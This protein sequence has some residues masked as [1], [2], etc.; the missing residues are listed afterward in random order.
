MAAVRAMAIICESVL[1]QLLPAIKPSADKHVLDVLPELWPRALAFVRAASADPSSVV[2]G[3]LAMD[4]GSASAASGATT[5]PGAVATRTQRSRLDMARIRRKSSGCEVVQKLLAAAF[6]AMGKAIANHAAE[7]LPA[8]ELKTDGSLTE[9]GKLCAANINPALKARYDAL[10][11]TSTSVERLHAIGRSVDQSAGLQRHEGR[12]GTSL[13]KFNDQSSWLLTKSSAA[14]QKLFNVTRSEARVARKTS[15]KQQRIASGRAKR[16]E[17]DAK[18]QTKRAR[19]EAKKAEQARISTV[20]LASTYSE[21]M[22]MAIPELQ[23]Q[24]KAWKL[25][26]ETGFTVTQADREAYVLQLQALIFDAH[27]SAANDLADGDS[28][29]GSGR[30]VRKRRVDGAGGRR[31]NIRELNGFQWLAHEEF[32]I[33]RLL[34]KKVEKVYVGKVNP[35]PQPNQPSPTTHNPRTITR[36]RCRELVEEP[37]KSST[38][39]FCGRATPPMWQPGSHQVKFTTILSTI[40]RLASKQK[41]NWK[42]KKRAW[43]QMTRTEVAV[44]PN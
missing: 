32:E 28:G 44:W 25:K 6:D 15:L 33:D 17:R 31:N 13:A 39:R 4:L 10:P 26:G 19:R 24:L 7:W 9:E 1:W 3:S 37:R 38:T 20:K 41:L 36:V 16:A 5:T 21:L 30:V 35:T 40:M 18:L 42:R 8:G 2:D 27:G 29:T 22:T 23:D 12:A 11:S 14:L 34:D 43:M